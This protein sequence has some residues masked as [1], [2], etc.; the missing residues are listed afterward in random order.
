M[1]VHIYDVSHEVVL[2]KLN[3][4]LA[5]K[6]SVFKLGGV[7]HAG[8]EVGGLEWSF[9]WNGADG[10]TGVVSDEPKQNPMHTFRQSIFLGKTQLSIT[11]VVA[12][13]SDMVEQ[14]PGSAYDLLQ[15]NCC[16]FADD[17]CQRLGVGGLPKWVHRLARAGAKV[18]SVF[19]RARSW[20]RGA[21][22]RS[23][24]KV[25]VHPNLGLT[26]DAATHDFVSRWDGGLRRSSF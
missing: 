23:T 7:F 2:Q 6:N 25:Q 11:E 17:F 14:Y 9:G 3:K 5:N 8:V 21:L 10:A 1:V 22:G 13:I 24:R 12:L 16:T 19:K 4:V 26:S 15:M 20:S 18:D